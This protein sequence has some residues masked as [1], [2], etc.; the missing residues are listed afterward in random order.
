MKTF[1]TL[2]FIQGEMPVEQETTELQIIQGEM[3]VEQE[4]TELQTAP[5]GAPEPSLPENRV[6]K[7]WS[8]LFGLLIIA[9]VYFVFIRPKSKRTKVNITIERNTL[10]S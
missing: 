6:P 3:P 7:E 2:L 9:V 5:C 1:N 8:Y 4:T 10:N